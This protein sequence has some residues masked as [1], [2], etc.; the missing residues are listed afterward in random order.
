MRARL[1]P[2]TVW[3]VRRPFGCRRADF[4]RVLDGSLRVPGDAG[5]VELLLA[6]GQPVE[7]VAVEPWDI[8]ITTP[9]DWTLALALEA[10]VPH[11]IRERRGTRDAAGDARSDLPSGVARLIGLAAS[12][13]ISCRTAPLR[14]ARRR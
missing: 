12:S 2:G 7:T 4:A 13:A 5:T 9:A 6:A 14:Y 8:K 1:G 10:I 11:P 3:L